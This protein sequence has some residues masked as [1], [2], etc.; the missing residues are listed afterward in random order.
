MDGSLTE[1]NTGKKDDSKKI[2]HCE[3]WECLIRTKFGFAQAK[4]TWSEQNN[5]GP[6]LLRCHFGT[7]QRDVT[8]AVTPQGAGGLWF[9]ASCLPGC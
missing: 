2:Y 8:A 9:R 3:L 7:N 6:E 4:S 5:K 1:K